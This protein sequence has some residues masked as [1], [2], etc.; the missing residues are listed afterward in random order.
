MSAEEYI[1][2]DEFIEEDGNLGTE[3]RRQLKAAPWYLTSAS[4]HMIILLLLMLIPTSNPRTPRQKIIINTQVIED[5][6]EEE[7]IEEPEDDPIKAVL[8]ETD[9]IM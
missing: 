5:I 7:E 2:D 6:E 9:S 8:K 4:G 1:G 3:I